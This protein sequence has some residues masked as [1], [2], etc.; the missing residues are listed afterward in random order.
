MN[1]TGTEAAGALAGENQG[2][3]SGIQSSGQVSGELHIGGLVGLNL[4]LVYLSRSSAAVTGM[5]PPFPPGVNIIVTYGPPAATGGLVGYNTG[6]VV[7]SYATGRVT[8]DRSAGGL[9]GYHQ[10]KLIAASYATGPVTG[11]PA[12]GL[13][14]TIATPFEEATIRASYATG[15]VDGGTA[16][17]LVGRVYD[18]GIITASYATG[19]VAGFR[20]GGLVG[21]DEGGTVTNSYWDTRT[22]AQ[23]SGSPGSGRT[24]S[25]LQSPTS[26]SGIYGSWNVDIDEDNMNDN[27]WAF[28][29]SSQYPALKADMD[30]D[31]DETWEEFGYQ[32]RSGPA[33]TATPTTNAGQSQ[34]ELEWTEVPLSSAWSPAPSLSY[35]VTRE[36]DENHRDHRRE[37]HRARVHGHRRS[38]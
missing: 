15:S 35:T 29:T 2:L 14:G 25:Q 9:V 24:T 33:L 37:P 1:V 13:V 3:L 30:G 34:V 21:D 7:L 8:S 5:R 16:G 27:P 6:F 31:D 12:G 10:S 36:D 23:G 22:S 26:Y 11:S 18:E 32:L 17:G 19:R 38:R 20:T 4:R 28:G